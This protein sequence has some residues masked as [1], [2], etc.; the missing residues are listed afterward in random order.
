VYHPG[1]QKKPT[2]LFAL[3]GFLFL[4]LF[5]QRA[6]KFMPFLPAIA[7]SDTQSTCSGVNR[8]LYLPIQSHTILK[9]LRHI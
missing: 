8:P 2:A 3:V 1:E 7:V 6:L 4:W 9:H 5:E